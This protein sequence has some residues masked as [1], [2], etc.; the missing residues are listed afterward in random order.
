MKIQKAIAAIIV[1]IL[2]TVVFFSACKKNDLPDT[3]GVL[4]FST[5]T[6]QFDTIFTTMGSTTKAFKVYNPGNKAVNIDEI[7][8]AGGNT[9][10]FRLNIDGTPTN[11]ATNVE[12]PA[13]DSLFIFVEV[14]VDPQNLNTPF[15]VADSVVFTSGSTQQRV[16]LVAWGQDANYY[17][18][19]NFADEGLPAFSYLDCNAGAN[20]TWT[21]DKPHVIFGSLIVKAGCTLTIEAGTH[22][23]F[24]KNSSLV[25]DSGATLIVNGLPDNKVTFGGT[26]LEDYM[27]DVPGQWG[28]YVQSIDNGQVYRSTI[29]GIWFY[30]NSTGN[31]IDNAI[32]KNAYHGIMVGDGCELELTNTEIYNNSGIG[33]IGLHTSI[34]GYNN[35]VSNCGQYSLG[36]F[37]GGDYDFRHCT[38]TNYWADGVRQTPTVFLIN[39][40]DSQAYPFNASFRN[41]IIYGNIDGEIGHDLAGTIALNY[42]HCLVKVDTD[43]DTS[44]PGMFTN[45]IINPNKEL[46]FVDTYNNDFRLDTLTVA[47]DAGDAAITNAAPTIV[48][49]NIGNNRIVNAG[50]DLGAYERQW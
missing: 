49:D 50:P 30:K 6:V 11:K 19:T 35:V 8:L 5:D 13:G 21:S 3:G 26:R 14:T 7:K 31:K 4:S 20:M 15:V 23:Y 40:D 27:Q 12:I 41:S 46:D 25:I 37:L 29:G 36:L 48:F 18:P 22:V 1:A 10:Q 2:G 39:H 47:E 32:I 9:S 42:D 16:M 24:Y 28:T 33:L 34:T 44:L 17:A 38:F 45:C 43:F